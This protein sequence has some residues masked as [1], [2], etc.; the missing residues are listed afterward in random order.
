MTFSGGVKTIFILE[1][2]A[3]KDE[4]LWLDGTL[5][6]TEQNT[7]PP[8]SFLQSFFKVIHKIIDKAA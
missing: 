6:A 1:A 2:L 3:E 4:C 7:S 8:L 5:R